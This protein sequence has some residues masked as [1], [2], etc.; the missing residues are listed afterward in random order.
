MFRTKYIYI[1]FK[2]LELDRDTV[3]ALIKF[4]RFTSVVYI[5][6]FLTSSIGCDSAV[7]DLNLYQQLFAYRRINQQLADEAL[8]VFRRHGWYLTPASPPKCQKM[9]SQGLPVNS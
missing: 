2:Q 9:K 5:P 7:N 4:C 6:Y 3:T 8:V 1:F